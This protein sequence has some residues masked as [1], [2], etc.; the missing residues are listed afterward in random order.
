MSIATI[1]SADSAT[2]QQALDALR[3]NENVLVLILPLQGV[4]VEDLV[5][6]LK[7]L[8]VRAAPV[9]TPTPQATALVSTEPSESSDVRARPFP[10]G[11]ENFLRSRKL[12]HNDRHLAVYEA[13]RRFSPT[14]DGD[15]WALDGVALCLVPPARSAADMALFTRQQI[16]EALYWSLGGDFDMVDYTLERLA[17]KESKLLQAWFKKAFRL[18]FLEPEL[19]EIPI[20]YKRFLK[21]HQLNDSTDALALCRRLHDFT[22]R[23]AAKTRCPLSA[24]QWKR[25]RRFG[26]YPVATGADLAMLSRED[27]RS[28]CGR[29]LT[30]PKG[31]PVSENEAGKLARKLE[32]WFERNFGLKFLD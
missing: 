11:Y 2:I 19:E 28:A 13:M 29:L 27:I 23:S 7:P 18:S 8:L 32:G 22:H 30:P 3:T 26:A 31:E 9:A 1:L 6:E 21:R 15:R 17:V 14:S 25:W 16:F 10:E 4:T 20:C 24:P 5:D 12:T